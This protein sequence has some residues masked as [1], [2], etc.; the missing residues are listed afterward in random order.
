MGQG[1]GQV[2]GQELLDVRAL[3]IVGLLELDD[4]EDLG[5]A[6]LSAFPFATR[7]IAS[8]LGVGIDIRGWT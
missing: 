4:T 2:L 5:R 6:G 7:V 1:E 8:G 3:D